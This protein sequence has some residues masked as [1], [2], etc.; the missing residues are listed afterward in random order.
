MQ[1]Y[2]Q[3]IVSASKI[4]S[5]AIISDLD[6]VIDNGL[7]LDDLITDI[8]R[9]INQQVTQQAMNAA[10]SCLVSLYTQHG[11]QTLRNKL[12]RF[13]T[14]HGEITVY[15]P[16]LELVATASA[17]AK[18]ALPIMPATASIASYR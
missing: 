1:A 8:S 7:G 11:W 14:I 4:I 2:D 5:E 16:D 18:R 9:C 12:V 15:S 17:I 6:S 10:S 13:K 3:A